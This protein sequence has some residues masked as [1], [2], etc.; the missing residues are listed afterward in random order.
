[1]TAPTPRVQ[2]MPRAQRR[3]QLLGAA[4]TVFVDK[5]YHATAM[6][7]IAEEAGVSKPVLYQHFPGK[8]ELY[9]ALL[10]E[11]CDRLEALVLEALETPGTHKER[12]YA[13]IR[14]FFRF[15]GDEG[16][17]FRLV[18]ESDLTNDPGVRHRLDA[19]EAQVADGI[20]ARIAQD[21][22]LPAEL[23][24]LLGVGL[25]GMS[26]VSARAWLSHPGG[27]DLETAALAA[28][29]LAWRGIGSFPPKESPDAIT[30]T[31]A[32]EAV[33]GA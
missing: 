25:A 6:E 22:G 28:G 8:L 7:D 15:V 32:D 27:M 4:L 13:T 12:V 23:A 24:T 18:F 19:L 33:G 14:A 16:F 21:T 2:R 17:A 30:A 31:T 1:M 20:A 11:Q 9:T 10:D 26:Q 29:R 5:G 3:A